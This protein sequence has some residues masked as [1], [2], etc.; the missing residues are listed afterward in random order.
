ML[1]DS[2]GKLITMNSERNDFAFYESIEG[3]MVSKNKKQMYFIGIIDI[4]THYGAKKQMEYTVKNIFCGPTISCV[5]PSRYGERFLKY[6]KEVV[7]K[8]SI[9]KKE[10]HNDKY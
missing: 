6:M 10:G 5:P 2:Y 1:D 8:F 9:N 4:L 3:G 7:V